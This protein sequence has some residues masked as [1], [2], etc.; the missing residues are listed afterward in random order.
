MIVSEP[1]SL[2]KTDLH[3]IE[4]GADEIKRLRAELVTKADEL[5]ATLRELRKVADDRDEARRLYCWFARCEP[6]GLN[7]VDQ[8]GILHQ[9]IEITA[10]QAAEARGWDCFKEN[11][12]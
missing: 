3:Y 4:D 5:A 12:R 8:H 6:R 10:E 1:E 2:C 9:L 7:V 11:K